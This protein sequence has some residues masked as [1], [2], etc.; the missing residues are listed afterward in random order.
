MRALLPL[1]L[2]L[3]LTACGGGSTTSSTS[4]PPPSTDTP[5]VAT[6]KTASMT[7]MIHDDVISADAYY[8]PGITVGAIGAGVDLGIPELPNLS[9]A[10]RAGGFALITAAKTGADIQDLNVSRVILV[11]DSISTE[12]APGSF[13]L[14]PVNNT[15]NQMGLLLPDGLD[16]T[17]LAIAFLDS[18]RQTVWLGVHLHPGNP[19]YRT[20]SQGQFTGESTEARYQPVLSYQHDAGGAASAL[21]TLLRKAGA[22]V[23]ETDAINGMMTYGETDKILARKGFSLL[24]MKLYL[25]ALNLSSAGYTL[26]AID[27]DLASLR[28]DSSARILLPVTLF[29]VTH[30][31][32]QTALD[33]QY[34]YLASPLFGDVAVP[35]AELDAVWPDNGSGRVAFVLWT[36]A[37]WVMPAI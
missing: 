36:P 30:F 6:V 13:R 15:K 10:E 24:D 28:A 4:A 25:T 29:G 11:K 31:A 2:T 9:A 32:I 14:V 18:A 3:A 16:A 26:T 8:V 23:S 27:S 22:N 19:G 35:R 12:L 20:Y 37:D 1:L 17:Y 5:L 34:L 7:A 33:S 21:A